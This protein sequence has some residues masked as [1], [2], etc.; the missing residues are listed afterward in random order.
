VGW[1][2]RRDRAHRLSSA[3]GAE[4]ERARRPLLLV[5][6]QHERVDAID[7]LPFED[8]ARDRDRLVSPSFAQD[9]FGCL[10]RGPFRFLL[11]TG[12][13]TRALGGIPRGQ[14]RLG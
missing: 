2:A 13:I 12:L 14:K 9:G 5:L 6:H 10:D 4:A 3:N 8:P 1:P 11:I 7:G